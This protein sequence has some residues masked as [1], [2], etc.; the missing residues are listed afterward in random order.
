MSNNG[1]NNENMNPFQN[2]DP[3]YTTV[4]L[5]GRPKTPNLNM[6]LRKRSQYIESNIIP[7]PYIIIHPQKPSPFSANL[8]INQLHKG[9]VYGSKPENI[10]NRFKYQKDFFAKELEGKQYNM[11]H[12][13]LEIAKTG[14]NL[15]QEINSANSL[16]NIYKR[17]ANEASRRAKEAA[18][19]S[20]STK[21]ARN[22]RMNKLKPNQTLKRNTVL[23]MK[24]SG[25]RPSGLRPSGLRP[26]G[27]RPSGPKP[28]SL[29]QS[30]AARRRKTR[31]N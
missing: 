10:L 20:V 9:T 12:K 16:T 7:S 8:Q 21:A 22:I 31:R 3:S 27:L 23:P 1:A 17:E 29:K 19:R 26:S 25:L 28:L 30:M 2:F 11:K 14:A 18:N 5:P 15:Q 6:N 24:P 4:T 13:N